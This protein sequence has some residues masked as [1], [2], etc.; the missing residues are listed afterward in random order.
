M[1]ALV[2]DKI[3]CP[4]DSAYN[5]ASLMACSV[6]RSISRGLHNALIPADSREKIY[7]ADTN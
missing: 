6:R 5:E 4:V 7:K 1:T 3:L 2:G